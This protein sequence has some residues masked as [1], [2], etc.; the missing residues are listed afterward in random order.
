[1]IKVIYSDLSYLN[2]PVIS[3]GIHQV[4]RWRDNTAVLYSFTH[5]FQMYTKCRKTAVR[6]CFGDDDA[7]NDGIVEMELTMLTSFYVY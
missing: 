3:V 5:A 7:F 4:I 6:F 2:H 1:M